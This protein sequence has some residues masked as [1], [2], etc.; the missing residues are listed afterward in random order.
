MFISP[1]NHLFEANGSYNWTPERVR[2]AWVNSMKELETALQNGA[3]TIVLT[4]GIPGAGKTTYIKDSSEAKSCNVVVF[5][6]TFVDCRAR[7]PLIEAAKRF[8]AKIIGIRFETPIETCIA[9][10]NARPSDRRVPEP[11][12]INMATRLANEPP[13]LVEGFD[14]VRIILGA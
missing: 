7:K 2:N 8:G 13:S 11:T 14:A 5:D 3:D 4:I 1:D 6:A 10:N 9:R 12:M